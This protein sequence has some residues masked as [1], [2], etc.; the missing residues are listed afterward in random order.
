[1]SWRP[2]AVG[3][4]VVQFREVT[5]RDWIAPISQA[6]H[7]VDAVAQTFHVVPESMFVL[8][9]NNYYDVFTFFALIPIRHF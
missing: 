5:L 7:S 1:M 4:D 2:H 6:N 8:Y 9:I 3:H